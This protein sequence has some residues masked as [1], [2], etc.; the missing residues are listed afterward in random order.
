MFE[1][2]PEAEW[3]FGIE[4]DYSMR[5]EAAGLFFWEK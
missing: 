1:V 2:E 5:S 3:L 4:M